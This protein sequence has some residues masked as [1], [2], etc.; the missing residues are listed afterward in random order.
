MTLLDKIIAE[1]KLQNQ[2]AS[3]LA[4]ISYRA[5]NGKRQKERNFADGV[6]NVGTIH[7]NTPKNPITKEMILDYQNE[8]QQQHYD[9][10]TNKLQ[11][12]PTGVTDNTIPFTAINYVPLGRPVKDEDINLEQQNLDA[13]YEDLNKEIQN[14]KI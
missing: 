11:Y 14:K 9:D 10:G 6:L 1:S 12:Y 8:Q 3:D 7:F 13:L 4:D 2:L 5:I